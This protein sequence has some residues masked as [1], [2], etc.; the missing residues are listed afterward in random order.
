MLNRVLQLRKQYGNVLNIFYDATSRQEFG[1]ALKDKIDERPSNW[2]EVKQ[3]IM[4]SVRRGI[5][6][7]KK[8]VIVPVMFNT[9][10]KLQMSA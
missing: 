4:E 8:M 5:P 10:S 9:E 1:T 7:E 6:I 3:K 2:P